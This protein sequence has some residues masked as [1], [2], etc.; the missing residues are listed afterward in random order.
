MCVIHGYN[1]FTFLCIMHTEMWVRIIDGKIRYTLIL[2]ALDPGPS[3]LLLL[4]P[5]T[6]VYAG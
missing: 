2:L 3:L 5:H 1:K 6:T 4:A